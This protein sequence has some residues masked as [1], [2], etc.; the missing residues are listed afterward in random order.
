MTFRIWCYQLHQEKSLASIGFPLMNSGSRGNE[1]HYWRIFER[2]SSSWQ[3]IVMG[4]WTLA[5]EFC[6]VNREFSHLWCIMNTMHQTLT[7]RAPIANI[8]KLLK[9]WKEGINY[10]T[11]NTKGGTDGQ[12][13]R[14]LKKISIVVFVNLLA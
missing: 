1:Q 9:T 12:T 4:Y 5:R 7:R 3:K 8:K 14:R 6:V 11:A 10:N 2:G 13:W